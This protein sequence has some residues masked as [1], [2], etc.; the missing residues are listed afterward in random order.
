MDAYYRAGAS[1]GTGA[2]VI[3]SRPVLI[4]NSRPAPPWP[5]R[6]LGPPRG[7]GPSS[8]SGEGQ[9]PNLF[10]SRAPDV[11]DVRHVCTTLEPG[12]PIIARLRLVFA[13]YCAL[14]GGCSLFAFKLIYRMKTTKFEFEVEG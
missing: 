4:L 12:L 9:L 2:G 11:A 7:T 8:G 1:S 13:D 6:P 3:R 5:P 10:I 14:E